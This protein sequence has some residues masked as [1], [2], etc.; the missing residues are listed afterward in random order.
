MS[1]PERQRY[2]ARQESTDHSCTRF[3]SRTEVKAGINC[4]QTDAF[5]YAWNADDDLC[6]AKMNDMAE[7][8]S[9]K[10]D[11]DPHCQQ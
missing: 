4:C 6:K 10:A 3:F 8:S 7:L 2:R 9:D 1:V 11:G 5:R